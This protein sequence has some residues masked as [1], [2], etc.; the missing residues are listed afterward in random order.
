MTVC[1]YGYRIFWE[2]KVQGKLEAALADLLQQDDEFQFYFCGCDILN[3]IAYDV[4]RQLQ[5]ERTEKKITLVRVTGPRKEDMGFL[6]NEAFDDTVTLTQL[7]WYQGDDARRRTITAWLLANSDVALCYQYD[8]FYEEGDPK[9]DRIP[10][11]LRGVRVDLTLEESYRRRREKVA[12][13]P[14]LLRGVFAPWRAGV[15]ARETARQLN[16]SM[17]QLRARRSLMRA[18]LGIGRA[19]ERAKRWW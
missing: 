7:K 4:V 13:M 1:F 11:G 16:I 5:Q 2:E 14:K 8:D 6:A 12:R 19:R 10:V 18:Y 17:A 15:P 3:W 9:P